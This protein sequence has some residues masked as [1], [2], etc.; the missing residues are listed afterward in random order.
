MMEDSA[1]VVTNTEGIPL[2][3]R[4]WITLLLLIVGVT[5]AGGSLGRVPMHAEDATLAQA[6]ASRTPRTA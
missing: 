5:L 4:A 1:T 2:V 3:A 6:D